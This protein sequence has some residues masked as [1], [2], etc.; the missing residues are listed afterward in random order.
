MTK[1]GSAAESCVCIDITAA[2]S[3]GMR[4]SY[5]SQPLRVQKE[6]TEQKASAAAMGPPE[7]KKIDTVLSF[8]PV[9][10]PC[11]LCTERAF[12]RLSPPF[13]R[14]RLDPANMPRRSSR[15]TR[16]HREWPRSSNSARRTSGSTPSS[17]HAPALFYAH[18]FGVLLLACIPVLGTPAALIGVT[19]S[20]NRHGG[21]AEQIIGITGVLLGIV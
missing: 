17:A 5:L 6:R 20:P 7:K 14:C 8:R 21:K 3:L 4:R 15:T 13:P 19:W 1:L 2:A 10:V 16:A 11:G 18:F 12:P 9:P